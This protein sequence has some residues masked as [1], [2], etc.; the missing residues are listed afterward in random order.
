MASGRRS[1]PKSFSER[2]RA[3]EGNA[4]E[5][6][7]LSKRERSQMLLQA[8]Q[9]CRVSE[10]NYSTAHHWYSIY[11]ETMG[12]HEEAIA[13]ARRALSLWIASHHRGHNC[14]PS[15][16]QV[17]VLGH[18]HSQS[19]LKPVCWPGLRSGTS[20][21]IRNPGHVT[22]RVAVFIGTAV[23]SYPGFGYATWSHLREPA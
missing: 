20:R 5:A 14:N 13:G 4:F 8:P 2:P 15:P 10:V 3:S 16:N 11:L 1:S 19:H 22:Q 9:D 23:G 7:R 6:V 18:Y 17:T 21:G 12:K